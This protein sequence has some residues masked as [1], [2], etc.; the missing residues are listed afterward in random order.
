MRFKIVETIRLAQG[1]ESSIEFI[2]NVVQRMFGK[3]NEIKRYYSL[4]GI[5]WYEIPGFKEVR[6]GSKLF[7]ELTRETIENINAI[8]RSM[9]AQV[10]DQTT[11]M[12]SKNAKFLD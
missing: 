7:V 5:L 1:V 11:E 8:N 4:F 9:A 2:P 3:K 10:Y 12:T 6:I